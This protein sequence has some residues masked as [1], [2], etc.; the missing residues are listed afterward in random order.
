MLLILHKCPEC[1]AAEGE[2]CRSPKG[3]KR[4]NMHDTRPFSLLQS[5]PENLPTKDPE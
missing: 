5:A 3:R 2:D 1:Q 4:K